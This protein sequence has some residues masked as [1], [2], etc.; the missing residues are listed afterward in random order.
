MSFRVK[1][2]AQVV[3]I[4]DMVNAKFERDVDAS[5]AKSVPPP[6]SKKSTS[7]IK[8][9]MLAAANHPPL[10]ISPDTSVSEAATLMLQ[11]DCQTENSNESSS[12]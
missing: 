9:G 11:H 8:L 7:K 3:E 1:P 2:K 12:S 4:S 10:C 5:L 6:I